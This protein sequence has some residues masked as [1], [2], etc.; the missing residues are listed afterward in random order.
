MTADKGTRSSLNRGNASKASDAS[1][2][3]D[4]VRVRFDAFE[5]D[6]VNA[7]LLHDRQPI[8]VAPTPFALLCALVR[9]GG[10]L[11]TK[12]ALL[13]AVWGH[14]Y[15]SDSVL[16]TAIS[17]LRTA[18]G[19]D[20]RRPRYIETVSRRG[21]RFIGR[22]SATLDAQP[23][24][25]L[26]STAPAQ[27]LIGRAGALSRL[28]RAW[29]LALAGKRMIV[30]VA[31]D[32]GVGKTTLVDRF[33]AQLRDVGIGRGQCVE[34]YGDGEPY[35]P[36]LD[37]IGELCRAERSVA[38]LLRTVAPFWLLQL[39]WLTTAEERETLR[40]ELAGSRPDRMLR[41]L[42]E[43]FDRYTEQ[44]PLVLVTEDVHWSDHATIQLMDYIARRRGHGR[45]MWIVTFRLAEI[46]AHDHP[47][48]V[49]R[50]EFRLH[51]LCDEIVLDP[52]SEEEV[53]AYIA[54]R[55]PS[56]AASDSDVRAL[57]ERTDGLPLFV[58]QLVGDL[59]ARKSLDR[60]NVSTA[61]LLERMAIPENLAAIIDLYVARL[62][63]EQ[64]SV[65]EAAAVCGI[66][67]R[68]DAVAT[69]LEQDAASVAAICDA[70]ARAYRWLAPSSEHPIDAANPTYRFRHALFHQGLYE[71][72][73][74][75]VR[76]QLH[77]RV[78][79]ALERDRAAGKTVAATELV[80]HFERGA[81]P[82]A[83]LRH[84]V[85]AAES[86]LHVSPTEV[87]RLT[88]RGLALV[89]RIERDPERDALEF[90][91]WTIR[92]VSAE[93]LLGMGSEDAKVALHR[94]YELLD[95][96]PQHPARGPL[97]FRLGFMLCLRAEYAD[98]LALAERIEALAQKA[99]D[100]A[101]L[102]AACTIQGQVQFLRG[103][104]GIARQWLERGLA[105]SDSL[106]DAGEGIFIADPRV[107]LFSQLAV[108]LLHLG[109]VER[110]RACVKE[111]R[112]RARER[113]QAIAEG[114]AIWNESL[115]EVRL[116]N[117]ER[118][119][120]LAEDM[121]AIAEKFAFAQGHAGSNWMRGWVR[122]RRGDPRGGF[123]LIREA[124][125]E[126]LRLGLRAGGSEMLGYAAEA[127]LRAGDWQ[128]AQ[129]QLD[130]AL[131]I[132]SAF[133]E[134]VYLPQLLLIEAAI[135]DARGDVA[136]AYKSMRRAVAEARVQEAPWLELMTLRELCVRDDATDDEQCSLA[137]LAAQFPEASACAAQ[138]GRA[139]FE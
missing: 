116:G 52:F 102:I 93:Q 65:L 115:V 79:A 95:D 20:A 94:A 110:A 112:T 63:T 13:D 53:A 5:L 87:M 129:R 74:P 114:V 69:V 51:G 64:R 48:K 81:E 135:A 26:E 124:Y 19:D 128:A 92:G 8:A 121:R 42:G 83:A 91:V 43:F 113:R 37:A 105:A 134:R 132:V 10:S 133:G 90:S 23:A 18:L 56:L 30:W 62:T 75:R 109:L 46:I 80:M 34:Q 25:A 130:E 50:N 35:L 44:R 108:Q 15:V 16:K 78:G 70:L 117:T 97:L 96:V 103:H 68:V 9:Q 107:T 7:R 84:C 32:P 138:I 38:E 136:S 3:T 106:A 118:V 4:P 14:R 61:G 99:D 98:A 55:A 122:A 76:A 104:P 60:A 36:I 22:A 40:R 127:L 24:G 58:A 85:Q 139:G 12:G 33:V 101:L 45:L 11:I 57:H 28:H 111:A 29:D 131:E 77:G 21:Y 123:R 1:A 49:V 39:P 119:A 31:G 2:S 89:D 17:E 86:L 137:M 27:D 66:E 82:K 126:D 6:E 88:E 125:E 47:L 67:F 54:Q 100:P 71:R 120:V 72:I 41:E 73:A 59:A